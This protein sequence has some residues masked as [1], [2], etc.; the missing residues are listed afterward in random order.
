MFGSISNPDKNPIYL[1][2]MEHDVFMQIISYIY[3]GLLSL[4]IKNHSS[5]D[6]LIKVAKIA[7]KMNLEELIKLC[8]YHLSLTINEKNVIQIFEQ[9][10]DSRH[11]LKKNMNYCYEIILKN[12]SNISRSEDFCSLEQNL[13]NQVVQNVIPKLAKIQKL[14]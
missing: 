5:S 4:D 9:V 3:T 14:K 11:I 2:E 13:M 1:K 10:F 12:F 8:S 6:L 7:D